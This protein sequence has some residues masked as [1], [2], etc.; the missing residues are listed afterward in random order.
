MAYKI[1]DPVVG[2]QPI[3]ESST[4]Q[5]HNAGARVRAADPVYGEAEFFYAQGVALTA[6]GDLVAFDTTAKTTTR[7][8]LAT[9]GPVGVAMS[10]N[11]ATQWGWYAIFGSVPVNSSAVVANASVYGTA[12]PGVTD[13]AVVA[14]SLING[15]RYKSTDAGGRATVQLSYPSADGLG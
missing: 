13:D 2:F 7:V 4:T 3:A 9:K 11:L 10:A 8:I 15:A 6:P 1:T 5:R 12:T 14:G